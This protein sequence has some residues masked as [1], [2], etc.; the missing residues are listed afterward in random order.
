[1]VG[2]PIVPVPLI[3][4]GVGPVRAIIK[5]VPG[6]GGQHIAEDLV[7]N[8]AG[9]RR[10]GT[11]TADNLGSVCG[12]TVRPGSAQLGGRPRLGG[13]RPGITST[14]FTST[15]FTSTGALRTS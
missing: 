15:G 3:A 9:R 1:V 7:Q 6:D 11:C 14:G 13:N 8:S 12:G 5:F 10:S 4:P 2:R